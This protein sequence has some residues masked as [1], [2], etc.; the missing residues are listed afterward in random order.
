MTGGAAMVRRYGQVRQVRGV[1][2]HHEHERRNAHP[3]EFERRSNRRVTFAKQVLL[4][5]IL[6]IL[7]IHSLHTPLLLK[8]KYLHEANQP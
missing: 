3:L 4:R 5:R 7:G 2:V 1:V 6:F 8:G